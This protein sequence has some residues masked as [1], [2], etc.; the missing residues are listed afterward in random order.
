[1]E[2]KKESK[3]MKALK[4]SLALVFILALV[5]CGVT[6]D[7][8]TMTPKQKLIIAYSVYNSQ[9]SSYMTD[10]G[11]SQSEA[12]EWKKV[13]EVTLTDSKKE[14]L[15]V[16]KDILSKMHPL[17]ELYSGMISGTSPYSVETETQLFLLID[18]LAALT[19]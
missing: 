19:L 2:Q 4:F 8:S 7:S 16:K 1:M 18:E 17:L 5:S 13:R 3:K 12:G 15:R 11:Y 14:V 6:T 9:Y 10:T